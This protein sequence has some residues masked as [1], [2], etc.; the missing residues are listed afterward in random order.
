M[1][2]VKKGVL[3]NF[4]KFTGKQLCW[5]LSFNKVAGLQAA[6]LLKTRLQHRSFPVNFVKILRTPIFTEYPW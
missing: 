5:S 1:C 3:K 4:A 2:Y 6:T